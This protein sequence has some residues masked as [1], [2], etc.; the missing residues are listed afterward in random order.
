MSDYSD[1]DMKN[2][3]HEEF[4]IDTEL[5]DNT[6][7]CCGMC[8]SKRE[9]LFSY[10]IPSKNLYCDQCITGVILQ[11]SEK[12]VI[13]P[14]KKKQ[15]VCIS[16]ENAYPE[17]GYLKGKTWSGE[18]IYIEMYDLRDNGKFLPGNVPELIPVSWIL[19]KGGDYFDI[20][21]CEV[22]TEEGWSIGEV[23][24][25]ASL[26]SGLVDEVAAEEL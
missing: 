4:Y 9:N 12:A 11:N 25:R 20:D 1:K 15:N 2:V 18:A 22:W 5:E 14:L 17:Y 26:P 7:V 8:S 6:E 10:R 3:V 24:S 21:S 13:D 19:R 23:V 16:L